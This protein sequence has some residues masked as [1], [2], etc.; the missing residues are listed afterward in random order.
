MGQGSPL[1]FLHGWQSGGSQ[2]LP[3]WETM[4]PSFHCF[5]PDCLGFGDSEK[6]TTIAS[7][8]EHEEVLYHYSQA[9]SLKRSIVIGHSLGA[10]I[11]LRYALN[12]PDRVRALVLWSPL[13]LGGGGDPWRKE[14]WLLSPGLR[15]LLILRPLLQPLGLRGWYQRQIAAR[16]RLRDQP[17]AAPLLWGRSGRAIQAE[18]LDEQ[19]SQ[20]TCPLL[21]LESDPAPPYSQSNRYARLLPQSTYQ[22]LPQPAEDKSP[23]STLAGAILPFLLEHQS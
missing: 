13:G 2:W 12:H 18:Y 20:I 23:E 4:G 16:Q 17:G 7:L 6:P 19:L 14:R 21:I 11:A 22:I 5:A 9:L 8:A 3:L 10:W 1:L 15:L